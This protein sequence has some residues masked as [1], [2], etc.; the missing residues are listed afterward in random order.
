MTLRI[1]LS[2]TLLT[3]A[4]GAAM[5]ATTAQDIRSA[6]YEDGALPEGQ[7]GLAVTVQVLL[8]RAGI[9]PG[10]IDGWK[11][12]MTES[13]LR[14]FEEREGLTVDG[15]MDAEVWQALGGPDAAPVLQDYTITA[16]DM[17]GLSDPLPED[18]AKLAELERI[19]YTSVAERLAERFHM[20]EEF[21]KALNPQAKF[22]EGETITVTD[23]GSDLETAIER[24]TVNAETRRLTAYGPDGKVIGD[25]PVTVGS[26]QT[27]SPSGTHEVVAV[28]IDPTYSYNPDVNFQQGDNDAPLTL[29]PGP[30]GPVGSVW[31]DLSKPTYGIHGTADPASLFTERSHGCVR[32]TNWDAQELAHLVSPGV[33]VEFLQ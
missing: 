14:A 21:L 3:F 28:A 17:Q 4:A 18:Y 5:A 31:I 30:N 12:G 2:T 20:D 16:E 25:Y 27:P 13:A 8:D 10:V 29:P 6:N 15:V 9:S 11:G 7:T 32:M 26:A 22:T 24:I 33:T 1:L 23:P 19:G